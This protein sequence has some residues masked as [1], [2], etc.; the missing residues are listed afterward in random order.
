MPL[1]AHLIKNFLT[2]YGTQRSLLRTQDTTTS[3]YSDAHY[4]TRHSHS[5]F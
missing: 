5:I 3:T 4:S 1:V 2:L